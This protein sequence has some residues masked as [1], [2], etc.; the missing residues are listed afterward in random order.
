MGQAAVR[1]AYRLLESRGIL[2]VTQ[3][4]GTFVSEALV[5]REEAVR[6]FQLEEQPSRLHLLEARK[7]IEPGI[8]FLAA[9]R[10]T[11]A[12]AEAILAF[13]LEVEEADPEPEE[14]G[15]LNLRFHDM[16]VAASHNPVL[17]QL[18]EVIHDE[19]M[20]RIRRRK[21]KPPAEI[22][23]EV[24]RKAVQLHKLI[25]LAV[26]E[27]NPEAARALMQQDLDDLEQLM[28]ERMQRER[29]AKSG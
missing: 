14:F 13:A 4:R 28:A 18:L 17:A 19:Q 10:A 15:E 3:G 22:R 27:G 2:E 5:D 23:E 26:K 16:I 8:T 1:E 7:L 25:A 21:R 24:V 20:E 9:Q 11:P 29:R 6:R 12:E